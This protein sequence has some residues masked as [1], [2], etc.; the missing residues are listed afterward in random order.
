MPPSVR[1]FAS[2]RTYLR[3][4][5]SFDDDHPAAPL[6]IDLRLVA[7]PAQPPVLPHEPLQLAQATQGVEIR[8]IA[9]PPRGEGGADIAH[10]R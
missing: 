10:A 1:R 5:A 6:P 3:G 9:R 7:T 8:S 4:T 2:G